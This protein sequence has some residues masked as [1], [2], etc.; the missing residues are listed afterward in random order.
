MGLAHSLLLG[1]GTVLLTERRIRELL[2]PTITDA[3]VE[4]MDIRV[5]GAGGRLRMTVTLDHHQRA[6]TLDECGMW[7]RRFEEALDLA[8]DVPREYAL[9]V[10]SP[11]LDW[12]LKQA[13]QFEKNVGRTLQLVYRAPELEDQLETTAKVARPVMGK[14]KK[15]KKLAAPPGHRLVEAEL[16]A[17][18]ENGIVMGESDLY[19]FDRITEA[20]VALPW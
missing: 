2:I 9:D 3:D 6:I 13:W 1:K 16:K 18:R 12:P 20:R 14:K 5:G 17:V 8:K 15:Q 7:S 11:G 10:S 19:E 4:V